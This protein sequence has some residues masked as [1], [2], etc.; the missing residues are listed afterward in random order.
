MNT[1][2]CPEVKGFNRRGFYRMKQF[3]ETYKENEFVNIVINKIYGGKGI[4]PKTLYKRKI[5]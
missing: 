3:Y 4:L 2:N 1:E 5:L